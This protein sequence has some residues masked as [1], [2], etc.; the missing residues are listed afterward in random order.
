MPKPSDLL[1]GTLDLLILKTLAREPLHGWAI[2]KKIQMLSD[3]VLSVQQGSLYPA[4]HRLENNGWIAAE[5]TNTEQGR[6]AKVYSLTREGKRQ[7]ER[8]LD[9]WTRLSSAVGL[10]L[11]RA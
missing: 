1:Q 4:L 2:S 8:E 9:S 7:L 6:A 10:L 5:W 11:Q 3:E